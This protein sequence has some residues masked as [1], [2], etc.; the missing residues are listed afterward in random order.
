MILDYQERLCKAKENKKDSNCIGTAL[1]LAG[2]TD[3]DG[4]YPTKDVFNDY[5]VNLEEISD[6][7]N[8]SLV[9]WLN[10]IGDEVLQV[11]HMGIITIER[12][13]CVTHRAGRE[14]KIITKH[15]LVR[16][17]VAYEGFWDYKFY[18]IPEII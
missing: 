3:K 15:S 9:A 18:N 17:N 11:P 7:E 16:L 14:D 5:L 2:L 10:V 6:A 8:G 12:P 1:Y 13:I 4:Y